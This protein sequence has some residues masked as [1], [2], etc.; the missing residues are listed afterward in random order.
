MIE[1]IITACLISDSTSKSCREFRFDMRDQP[2]I[3]CQ[4]TGWAPASKWG[5]DHPDWRVTEWHCQDT[6]PSKH[7][8]DT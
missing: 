4:M 2:L 8:K 1:L 5:A 6:D 7:E 3:Q